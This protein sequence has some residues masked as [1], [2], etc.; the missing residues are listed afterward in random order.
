[1]NALKERLKPIVHLSD[2]LEVKGGKEA[3]K[4]Y[5]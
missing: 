5:I 2:M 1:M 3:R 4:D